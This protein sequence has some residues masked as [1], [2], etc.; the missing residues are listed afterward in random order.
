MIDGYNGLTGMV[1][2]IVL[3]GLAYVPNQV[4]DRTDLND[5]Y[6]Y[7]KDTLAENNVAYKRNPEHHDFRA[8]DVRH[9]QADVFKGKNLLGFDPKYKLK[10][11]IAEAMPWYVRLLQK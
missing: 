6:R 2:V 7:R 1:T 9:S 4:V 5:L 11:G 10:D 3:T 8:G